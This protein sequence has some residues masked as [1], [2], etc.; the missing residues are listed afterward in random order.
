MRIQKF[1]PSLMVVG[2]WTGAALAQ[3][4]ALP[5]SYSRTV[6]LPVVGLAS[7]E[8]AQVNV[9]NLAPSAEPVTGGTVPS[10]GN[11]ASCTGGITF[12]DISGNALTSSPSFTIGTGQ[13]FS[14]T[15]PYSQIP[16]SSTSASGRTAIRAVV[17][18]TGTP[19]LST[20]PCSLAANIE[21]FDTSTGVTHV[22]V[23]GGTLPLSGL[24]GVLKS[25]ER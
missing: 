6:N 21:T 12:Y 1:V 7:S 20:A 5:A 11:T 17:T 13:I 22:H 24:V 8:T 15:L 19:S 25:L 18:I 4:A 23:E 16:A 14:A 9:V 2:L 10:G 3:N